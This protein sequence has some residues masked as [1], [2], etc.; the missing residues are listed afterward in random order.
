MFTH[1]CAHIKYMYTHRTYTYMHSCTHW[2][3]RNIFTPVYA[4]IYQR[5]YA[6]IY[7]QVCTQ[8]IYAYMFKSCV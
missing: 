3:T 2:C 5:I 6:S 1:M 4:C 8:R 7:I